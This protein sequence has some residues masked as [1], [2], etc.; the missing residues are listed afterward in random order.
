MNLKRRGGIL[1]SIQAAGRPEPGLQVRRGQRCSWAQ[2][3]GRLHEPEKEW[4]ADQRA[5]NANPHDGMAHARWINGLI[6]R[7]VNRGEIDEAI[8][9]Y[10]RQR[11][12]AP[13]LDP[14]PLVNLMMRRNLQRP[15]A[16][17]NWREVEVLLD[18]V[19]KSAPDSVELVVRR[20]ILF[21]EQDQQAK[22]REVLETARSRFPEAVEPWTAEAELLV[23]QKKF[24][25]A[26]RRL[27]D[28]RKQLG[29]RIELRLA[30]ATIWA[31]RGAPQEEVVRALNGLAE[32][33]GSFPKEKRRSLLTYLAGEL[34]VQRDVK[35]AEGIWSRLAVEDREDLNPHLHL[36]EIALQAADKAAA[37]KQ[38][39]AKAKA[40]ID[41]RIEAIERIDRTYGRFFRARYL[42]W[43]AARSGDEAERKRLRA[44]AHA[45]LA[46]LKTRRDEWEQIPVAEAVL[47]EQELA[48]AGLDEVRKREKQESLI[49]LYLNAIDLGWRNPAVVRRAVELL[50]TTGRTNEA[51]QL[52]SRLPAASQ[53]GGDLLQTVAQVAGARN[54]QQAEEVIRKA[55]E[56][57]RK[58]VAAKPGNFQERVWLANIL[59]AGKRA[60]EAED[61]LR[62]A[63]AQAKGDPDR[64]RTLVTFLIQT[65]QLPKAE[66]ALRD[67][68]KNL[69]QAPLALAECCELIGRANEGPTTIAQAKRWYDDARRWFDKAI[70]AR[71]DTKDL[72]V[73]RRFVEF[74]RHTDPVEAEK[75][76][77]EILGQAAG[78][79]DAVTFAW[80]RSSLALMYIK[81]NPRRPAEALALFDTAG[82]EGAGDDP[83]DAK[84]VELDKR[85]RAN[86]L[87]AQGTPEHRR[88]AIEILESLVDEKRAAPE[89][90][91]LLAQIEEA[92]GDWPKAR[93]QY[94]KLIERTKNPANSDSRR[95]QAAYL[96]EF[97]DRLLQPHQPK[98]DDDLAE[99]QE[100][101]EK[102]K[103]IQPDLMVSVLLDVALYAARKDFEGA[104]TLIRSNAERPNLN[105]TA[106]ERSWPAWPRRSTI[107]SWPR[108]FNTARA[109]GRPGSPL[110]PEQGVPDQ[111]PRTPRR[112]TSS[113]MSSKLCESLRKNANDRGQVDGLCLEI[114][115]RPNIPASPEQINRVIGWFEE[116][117]RNDQQA[118]F[119][120]IG[121]GKLCERLGQFKPAGGALPQDRGRPGSP[122]SAEQ[123]RTDL[124]SAYAADAS[125][126]SSIS[127]RIPPEGCRRPRAG[128]HAGASRSSAIPAPPPSTSRSAASSAGSMRRVGTLSNHSSTSSAWATSTS[129]SGRTMRR[130]N[131]TAPSSIATIRMGSRPTTSPG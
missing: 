66:Q 46:Q 90:Q 87:V 61:V 48:E 28:A 16:Q 23:R 93:D 31:T 91:L 71:K 118:M 35:D 75:R 8:K 4:E 114:F 13:Q 32:D 38:V 37:D 62:D 17:R 27:D 3:Y 100:Q 68:E 55:E 109:S 127:L 129:D 69:P 86:V 6:N 43:Q 105:P 82:P 21:A 63:I 42:A 84:R 99:A 58:A 73:T 126:R 40:E 15:P 97:A 49:T 12:R 128:G 56:M 53:L 52:F 44:D 92:A 85:V 121:L 1:A 7:L 59:M 26:L 89:D 39:D 2:C 24:V 81:D 65:K 131:I 95:R 14:M 103:R 112:R 11:E 124:T 64:W 34:A 94:R 45:L 18:E 125:R 19:A 9:E 51:I 77:K 5:F 41:A 113:L 10:Q 36:F 67:A 20:A 78:A 60:A 116:E 130:R 120:Q 108:S 102:L 107:P 29:D 98:Q 111:V 115:S 33:L 47:G 122:P 80:A 25:D 101:I 22:A 76:L 117:S 79:K 83:D 70:A 104:A 119:Y 72:S 88:E 123:D 57:A 74:L 54:Y 110:Q 30:R 106:L 96:A 50:F